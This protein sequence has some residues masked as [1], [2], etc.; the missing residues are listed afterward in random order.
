MLRQLPINQTNQRKLQERAG[1]IGGMQ[2]GKGLMCFKMLSAS[3]RIIGKLSLGF[4]V[5]IVGLGFSNAANLHD[6][7]V[8]DREFL[9]AAVFQVWTHDIF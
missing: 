6:S 5:F 9:V 1:L 4:V 3:T 7:L 8:E 2:R